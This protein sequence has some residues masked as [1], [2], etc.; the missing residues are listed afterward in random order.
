MKMASIYNNDGEREAMTDKQFLNHLVEILTI[1][2]KSKSL[3]EFKKA[4][5]EMIS[6]YNE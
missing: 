3:E 5:Q 6:S 1:A 2:E 4:L